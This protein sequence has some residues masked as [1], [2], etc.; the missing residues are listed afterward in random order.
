[1]TAYIQILHVSS[2]GHFQALDMKRREKEEQE[3]SIDLVE[4]APYMVCG[5]LKQT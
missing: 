2:I 1:M 4:P 5:R 3:K